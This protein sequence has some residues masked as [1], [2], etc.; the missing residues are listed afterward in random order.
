MHKNDGLNTVQSI[1][2]SNAMVK[3]HFYS[4]VD[5]MF[6]LILIISKMLIPLKEA[7]VKIDLY[8]SYSYRI[9]ESFKTVSQNCIQSAFNDLRQYQPS[10][11][12]AD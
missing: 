9:E 11:R 6:K 10:P 2:G 1:E 3:I 5:K 8:A 12:I 7:F 4:F